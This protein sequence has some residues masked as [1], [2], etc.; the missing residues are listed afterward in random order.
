MD[1]V[2]KL[3]NSRFLDGHPSHSARF[4]GSFAVF[5]RTRSWTPRLQKMFEP[6]INAVS[7]QRKCDLL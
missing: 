1:M 4:V 3:D 5:A 2:L 7:Y 6:N